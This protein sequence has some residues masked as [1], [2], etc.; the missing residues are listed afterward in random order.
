MVKSFY[1]FFW[2]LVYP[3]S[4][5]ENI[6]EPASIVVNISIIITTS[7]FFNIYQAN[8]KAQFFI[9]K[10]RNLYYWCERLYAE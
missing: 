6:E 9:D 8:C 10:H 3:H 5:L 1:T 2:L 7:S 4:N